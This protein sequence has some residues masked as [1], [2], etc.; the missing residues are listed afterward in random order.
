MSKAGCVN[1]STRS[2][3]ASL[4]PR[5]VSWRRSPYFDR[6][7]DE[8]L[9]D[10]G[11][12]PLEAGGGSPATLP[13]AGARPFAP[14]SALGVQLV[15]GDL[16]ATGIGTVTESDVVLAAASNALVVGFSVVAD[17]NR[18]GLLVWAE[19]RQ[20]EAIQA[21]VEQFLKQMPMAAEMPSL[22][23]WSM[24]VYASCSSFWRARLT[25]SSSALTAASSR[26]LRTKK[27]SPGRIS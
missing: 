22:R 18:D 1:F 5:A 2:K 16:S 4:S 19:P 8:L 21:A 20:Q 26:R 17:P 24:S 3:P 27:R 13:R 14:G 25:M 6:L 23:T 10:Y 12:V 7:L 9:R 11:I 15:R